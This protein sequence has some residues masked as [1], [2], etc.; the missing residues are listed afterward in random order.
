MGLSTVLF[1]L[2]WGGMFIGSFV[3]RLCGLCF[4][5]F[6]CFF[7]F[8]LGFGVLVLIVVCVV[9]WF[10][11]FLC[12]RC[13]LLFLEGL[14]VFVFLLLLYVDYSLAISGWDWLLGVLWGFGVWGFDVFLCRVSLSCFVFGGVVL[15]TC[16]VLGCGLVLLLVDFVVLV[17]GVWAV[18]GVNLFW[19]LGFRCVF[20]WFVC[21]CFLCICGCCGLFLGVFCFSFG[22]RGFGVTSD[23]LVGL[24]G[25]L[26]C[27]LLVGWRFGVVV[28][29]VCFMFSFR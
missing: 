5:C 12:I 28:W 9:L 17:G 29:F 3:Y 24:A 2:L 21:I 18:V 4:C 8:W 7:V 10:C 15:F 16:F 25:G 11:W 1:F 19:V 20:C 26:G 13:A 23:S 14:C 27:S 22:L 6:C